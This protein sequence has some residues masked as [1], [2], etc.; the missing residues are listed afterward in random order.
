MLPTGVTIDYLK[1][2]RGGVGVE[3]SVEHA[4]LIKALEAGESEVELSASLRDEEGKGED[5]ARMKLRCN[6]R[7]G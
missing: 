6:L 1:K 5:V 3:C 2:A 4:E 7:K